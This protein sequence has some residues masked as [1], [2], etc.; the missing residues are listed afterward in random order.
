M[1]DDRRNYVIVGTFVLAMVAALIV[2]IALV[3]GRTGA[4][5]PYYIV[6]Q[7]VRGLKEGV[8]ILFEGYPVGLI[9]SIQPLEDGEG[10]RVDVSVR[11]GWPI[12]DDSAAAI[13]AGLF[14]AS[15][16]DIAGGESPRSLEPGA[17]IPSSEGGDP[18][19]SV[20][21]LATEVSSL[22]REQIAPLLEDVRADLPEIVANVRSVTTE[23]KT[24]VD[25]LNGLLA[26]QNTQRIENILVNLDEATTEAN[27]I[28]GELGTTRANIDGVVQKMDRL[29]EEDQGD[30][31]V[32]VADLRYSLATLTRHI[33]AISANL[34][35]ATRNMNE[36]SRQV[37]DNPGVLLRGRD[38]GG[39]GN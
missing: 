14:A 33:D 35:A 17:R 27:S 16:I 22:V 30:L 12:P 7:N 4:T 1:R 23:A 28:V 36:F 25:R 39:D 37:R 20:G 38:G 18:L 3:S 32:A 9:E 11:R 10:F 19:A 6:F 31:A 5:D 2:W 34:E 13:S 15:V 29:L 24:T 8:E 21:S 26:R